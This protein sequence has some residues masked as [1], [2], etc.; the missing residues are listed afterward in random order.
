MPPTRRGARRRTAA[1]TKSARASRRLSVRRG[2]PFKRESRG[3]G[4]AAAGNDDDGLPLSDEALLLVFSALAAAT[5]D[6][7][8]CA[9]TCRRWR[10]LVSADAA[11]ICR[12]ATPRSDPFVRS[13]ALGFFQSRTDASAAPPR[14]VPLSVAG[15]SI[16]PSLAA[17]VGGASRVA[18]SR[19]GR[20]VLDL[21]RRASSRATHAVRLGACNPVTAG[22][23]GVD[24]LPPL[25]GKDSPTGPY[26]CTVITAADEHGG[27]DRRASHHASYRVLLLYNRRSFTALR[28]YSSDAGSWGPEAVVTGARIG[29]NQL[30]VRPHAAVVHHGVVFWPRLAVALRLDSLLQPPP[31]ASAAAKSKGSKT[32][33]RH[34]V[35]GFSPAARQRPSSQAERL[36]GVTP[37]GRMLRVEADSETIRAY[38]GGGGDGDGDIRGASLTG[39]KLDWK[40]TMKQALMRVHTVRLRWLCEKSGLVIFTARNGGDPDTHVYTVDVETKQ[41]RRVATCGEP[42]SP[43]EM[44]GYE[45][46]RVT[47]LASLGR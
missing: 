24:V 34:T 44:C 47:L 42:A 14:F 18:A 1:A 12:R 25:R 8:C 10:R 26:A 40:W 22:C 6:L 39:E 35:A 33:P 2:E 32:P 3:G 15:A 43:G 4:G 27:E 31:A 20:L 41:F 38:C 11:F 7:V 13:L 37:D 5:A 23:G 36:L 16:Q 30:A 46:D 29:R 45:M 17:L 9:A 28:C 19:N 21:R